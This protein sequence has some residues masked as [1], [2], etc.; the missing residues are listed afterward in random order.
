MIVYA[1]L[2]RGDTSSAT[3]YNPDT[4][5]WTILPTPP[6]SPRRGIGLAWSSDTGMMFAWG[7]AADPNSALSDGAAFDT[8]TMT[9]LRLPDAPP[10]S[11][12][13]G[14]AVAAIGDVLYVDGGRPAS[15]PL[16]LKPQ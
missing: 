4:D 2:V 9:W 7:G 10:L 1:G 13:S 3:S 6:I 5:E 14:H 11:A 15:G 8:S 16:I 12:R